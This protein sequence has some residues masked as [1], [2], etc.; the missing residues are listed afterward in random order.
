MEVP[1]FGRNFFKTL[2]EKYGI[3]HNIAYLYHQKT[4]GQV[5]VSNREIKKILEKTVNANKMDWLMKINDVLWAYF[6][7]YKNLMG[8]TP[9]QFVYGKS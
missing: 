6:T 1:I 8:M 3:H 9:Y 2:I 5:E 7:T 4:S